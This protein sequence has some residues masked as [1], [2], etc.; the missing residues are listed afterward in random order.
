MLNLLV[1]VCVAIALLASIPA[2]ALDPDVH[3]NDYHHQTWGRKDGAPANISGITQSDDGWLWVSTDFGLYRFDGLRFERYQS[4][5]GKKLRGVRIAVI[6]AAPKGEVWVGYFDGGIDLIRNGEIVTLP[7]VAASLSIVHDIEAASDG[8][9]WISTREYL[10]RWSNG[11]LQQIGPSWGLPQKGGAMLAIDQYEQLWAKVDQ[12]WYKLPR[13]ARR[14]VSSN[15]GNMDDIVPAADGSLWW[16]NGTQ[17]QRVLNEHPGPAATRNRLL[18][19]Y[20]SDGRF[21]FDDGGNLWLLQAP[22][23]IAR[24]RRQDLPPGDSFDTA[25]LP[26]EELSQLRQAGNPYPNRQLED[27]EGNHWVASRSGLERFRN[28]RI[29]TIA[30]PEGAERFMV[31]TDQQGKVWVG[32]L[33][34]ERLWDVAH[35]P[36][37]R[38]LNGARPIPSRGLHGALLTVGARGIEGSLYASKP[39]GVIPL[40]PACPKARA[41]DINILSE[42]R[43]SLWTAIFT[44]GLHRYRDG[45]WATGPSLGLPNLLNPLVADRDGAMWLA[46][47]DGVL[48]HYLNGNLTNYTTADG[49]PLGAI[50]LINVEQDVLT[51]SSNGTAVLREGRLWRLSS[52]EPEA[53]MSLAGMMILPNGDRWLHTALGMAQVLAADW[54]ASMQ[55]TRVPLRMQLL[56]AADGYQGGPSILPALHNASRDADGKIWFATTE[57]IGVLDPENHYRNPVPPVVQVSTLTVDHRPYWLQPKLQLPPSPGQIEIGFSAVSLTIPEKMQVLYKLEGVDADWQAAGTRR[58]ASYA[59][60]A[61]GDYRFLLK[62]ANRD[63]VWSQQEAVLPLSIPPSFTQTVWFYL[64]CVVVVSAL[65]YGL[66]LLRMRQVIG[67]MNALLGERLLERE[68]IAR[69]L[70]DNWLQDMHGL[71]LNFAGLSRG[72]PQQSPA[73][74]RMEELLLQADGVL[75]NGR[76]AVM[77]LR[78]AS[79]QS[80][81]VEQAF[82]ALGQRLQHDLGPRFG[83]RIRGTMRPLDCAAWEEIYYIGYEALHN[84][85]HHAEA[86][87]I[88]LTLD[89][90]VNQFALMVRDDGKGLPAEVREHGK[91]E[92]HWG[93]VGMRERARMVDGSMTF[94]SPNGHGTE[95]CLHIP[96][97]RAYAAGMRAGWRSRLQARWRVWRRPST[98]SRLS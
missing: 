66:Y 36:A 64:L 25:K 59:K 91:R 86:A 90:G 55:D 63:G 4:P 71:V 35:A 80:N 26:A 1:Q 23:G 7:P 78:A 62:A 74:E 81:D 16:R 77:G 30:L 87:R 6:A 47:R 29:R 50:R 65:G 92:G 68:R 84:A 58:S 44:C 17:F 39:G 32:A 9:V 95:I 75:I 82:T 73:R 21:M 3:L 42:D 11:Q 10:W 48:R 76:N 97:P 41:Q 60:L 69:A 49:N 52:T 83:L 46:S 43:Q 12:E 94:H 14:F 34:L 72:L 20:S 85:Y 13:N 89:Y 54:R 2:W 8:T 61:P 22:K 93:L 98:A 88:T 28:Q 38:V 79:V 67:R 18:R 24:I 31:G 51:S 70:H 40:P 19:H 5:S 57:G 56:D 33:N 15:V 96:A 27:R 37:P 53:L 45:V